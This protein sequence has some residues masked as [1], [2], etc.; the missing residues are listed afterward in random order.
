MNMKR[1]EFLV[2]GGLSW[3]V[4]SLFAGKFFDKNIKNIKNPFLETAIAANSHP[5]DLLLRFVSVA[6]T[7]TGAKGQYAVAR[8]MNFY[9]QKNPYDLVILA[10]DNIYNNGEI[11]KIEAVFERPYQPLLKKGVKFHACLGNHDIRTDNG[12]PQVNYPGFNMQGRYYT[13]LRDNVQFFALD[14]NGNADWKNQLIWLEK[15]LSLSKAAWKIVFGHHPIY[16]SGVYGSNPNFIKTFTPLF[17]KYGV[18]LYI[19]GHEHHY[20]RTRSINGTTYLI[21]GAGA[22]NRSVG[23]SEWTEYST[24]NLSFAAYDVYVDRIEVSGI[25]TNNRVFDR[26]LIGVKGV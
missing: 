25:G 26:G 8:A 7:G 11:E 17:Q 9:H 22:G 5:Q 3:F 14:T 10:G 13:F 18:Q 24:S 20:E 15:E 1:R 2:L 6:D 12:V 16:A 4:S 19:N 21:C 23:R